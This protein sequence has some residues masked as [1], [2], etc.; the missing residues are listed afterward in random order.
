MRNF[1]RRR[2]VAGLAAFLGI[3]AATLSQTPAQPK[4]L[5][6]KDPQALTLGYVANA[7]KVD[8]K[9]NPTYKAG[10]TCANCVLLTGKEGDA[11]RPCAVFPGKTVAAS[12]WCRSW[13]KRS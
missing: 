13:V 3:P 6:E 5:D 2:V 4:P 11:F 9:K 7:S 8:V 12:G 1:N 10:Q